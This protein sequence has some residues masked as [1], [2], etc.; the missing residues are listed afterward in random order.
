MCKKI[1]PLKKQQYKKVNNN[2]RWV[3]MLLKSINQKV[4]VIDQVI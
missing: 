2:P 3:D 1:K 4:C